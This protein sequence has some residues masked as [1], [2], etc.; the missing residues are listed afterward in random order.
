MGFF[1]LAMSLRLE[2]LKPPEGSGPCN[3]A[4]IGHPF[5]TPEGQQTTLSV[6]VTI[7]DGDFAG[8]IATIKDFGG[9][10]IPP[11]EGQ[12]GVT[13]WFLP[14]PCAAVRISPP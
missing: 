5:K 2:D 6:T 13:S 4:F 12:S 9:I 14:W 3:V 8:L 1:Q 7:E 10:F 11:E